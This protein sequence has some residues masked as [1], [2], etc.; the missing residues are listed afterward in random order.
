MVA[1]WSFWPILL[2]LVPLGI[3]IL[4]FLFA[5]GVLLNGQY[6][7]SLNI[8]GAADKTAGN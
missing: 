6:C 1:L 5:D 4:L 2:V 8:V 3:S 7:C